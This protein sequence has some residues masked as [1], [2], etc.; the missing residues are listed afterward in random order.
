MCLSDQSCNTGENL[1]SLLNLYETYDLR[2]LILKKHTV[3][4]NRV[5]PILEGE[6]W[7]CQM[8]KEMCLSKMGFLPT[9]IGKNDIET[10]LEIICTE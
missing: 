7:K 5:N 2:T 3:K 4:I 1:T 6:E 8:I 9:D 10:M